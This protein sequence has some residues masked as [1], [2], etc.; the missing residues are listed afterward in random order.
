[1]E[2]KIKKLGVAQ[3]TVGWL[4]TGL[5]NGTIKIMESTIKGNGNHGLWAKVYTEGID[6]KLHESMSQF[7]AAYNQYGLRPG[8]YDKAC[9]Y[10]TCAEYEDRDYLWTDAAWQTLMSLATNWCEMCNE[11]ISTES[12]KEYNIKRVEVTQ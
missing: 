7:L 11:A 3:G 1:M 8:E 10:Q 5:A 2:I 4:A 9:T 6:G 12:P